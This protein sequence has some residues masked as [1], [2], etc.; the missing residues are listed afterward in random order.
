MQAT[1]IHRS[2]PTLRPYQVDA[3]DCARCRVRGG[4]RRV[5]H[6]APA[7]ANKTVGGSNLVALAA[8]LEESVYCAAVAFFDALDGAGG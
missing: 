3:V 1:E 6:V 7:G 2:A 8:Q 5:G 4:A